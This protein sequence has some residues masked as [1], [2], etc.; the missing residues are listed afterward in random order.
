MFR[1]AI[2]P[3]ILGILTTGG[4]IAVTGCTPT[5]SYSRKDP[6]LAIHVKPSSSKCVVGETVTFF[7]RT[8]N[9]LGRNAKIEWSTTGGTLKTEDE[10]RVARVMFDK[11]GTYSVDGV[12]MADG[13]EIDRS[14]NIVTVTPLP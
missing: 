13:R 1:F 2:T 3:L 8:E 12:L 4:L 5:T 6:A 14:T 7:S 10:N 11:P 9:T